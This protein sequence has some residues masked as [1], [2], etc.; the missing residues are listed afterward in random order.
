MDIRVARA[1][2]EDALIV[3]ALQLQ[4]DREHGGANR[5][6]FLDEYADAWLTQ[7][8]RLPTWLAREADGTAVGVV[9]ARFD[10]KLPSLCRPTTAVMH[11]AS[12]FVRPQERGNGVAERMLRDALDWGHQQG[13]QRYTLNS[14]PKA[15]T[16]YERLGFGA[17]DDRWMERSGD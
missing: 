4:A 1:E 11:I 17:P 10:R 16:L 5:P 15:R 8:E 12:V 7:F 3:A 13:V 14:E 2:R 6:G 9:V